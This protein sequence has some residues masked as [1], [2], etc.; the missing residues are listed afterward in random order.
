MRIPNFIKK[1]YIYLWLKKID[2]LRYFVQNVKHLYLSYYL[3]KFGIQV[4]KEILSIERPSVIIMPRSGTLLG[5]F[6]DNTLIPH[7]ADLDLILYD[8][9]S[10]LGWIDFRDKLI[11]KK[12]KHKPIYWHGN[13]LVLS[14]SKHNV[15]INILISIFNYDNQKWSFSIIDSKKKLV[16]PFPYNLSTD[17]KD[18]I[19]LNI[20]SFKIKIPKNTQYLLE[21]WYGYNWRLPDRYLNQYNH[22]QLDI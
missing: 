3:R 19:I 5:L 10:G 7:D 6:R 14:I 11:L 22:N 12:F 8:Y 17:P 4:L 21:S 1:S 13:K 9:N 20:D 2:Q 16:I 18:F 15:N